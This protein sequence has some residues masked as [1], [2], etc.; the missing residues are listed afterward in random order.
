MI[1]IS[2]ID[3]KLSIY[4]ENTVVIF[5]A[6][7]FGRKIWRYLQNLGIEVAYFCDNS[8]ERQK[9]T[10]FGISVISPETLGKI[11]NEEAK[12]GKSVLVQVAMM[13]ENEESV[14]CQLKEMGITNIIVTEEA[15]QMLDYYGKCDNLRKYPEL[16]ELSQKA[17]YGKYFSERAVDTRDYL[18]MYQEK[19]MFFVC[20]VGKTGDVTVEN[21][22]IKN[23]IACQQTHVPAFINRKYISEKTKVKIVVGIREPIGRAISNRYQWISSISEQLYSEKMND[24]Q[25]VFDQELKNPGEFLYHFSR[26]LM[27][28]M[29]DCPQ[30]TELEAWFSGFGENVV[31]VLKYPFDKKAGYTIIQEGNIDI[32]FY[33]LERL[34]D[35]IPQFSD[36]VG[37]PF[38]TL[39][40][41][42]VASGKWIAESY[43][44]AQKELKFSKEYFED[45]YND[46]YVQHCYS[47]EDIEK[48]KERW[49]KNIDPNKK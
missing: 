36:W 47:P 25:W 43:K 29:K 6:G 5:G 39:E 41:G 33:Q 8:P 38:E 24:A 1:P 15:L 10:M 3:T 34:N 14:L 19:K 30:T 9:E 40:N 22:L 37:V 42:N 20:M 35:I 21:T 4:K 31:D 23:N 11:H 16:L 13:A 27:E 46:P 26:G 44:K 32:F 45:C 18:L 7:I 49:R 28:P 17:P 2:K 12:G 48:F